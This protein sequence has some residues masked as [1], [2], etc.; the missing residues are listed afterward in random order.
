MAGCYDAASFETDPFFQAI[1][2]P[3]PTSGVINN[4][5]VTGTMY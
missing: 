3:I 1:A 4:Q 5:A 2:N